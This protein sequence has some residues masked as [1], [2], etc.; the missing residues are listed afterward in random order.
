MFDVISFLF[1]LTLSRISDVISICWIFFII[2]NGI[3]SLQ[4]SV[5]HKNIGKG[6]KGNNEKVQV[7]HKHGHKESE[8]QALTFV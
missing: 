3:F 1:L 7:G 2:F 5:S 4:Y 8:R 6:W